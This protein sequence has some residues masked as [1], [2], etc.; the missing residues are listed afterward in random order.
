MEKPSVITKKC[1]E[2]RSTRSLRKARSTDNIP[3]KNRRLLSYTKLTE[4]HI[5]QVFSTCFSHNF[6]DCIH[7]DAQL[8]CYQFKRFIRTQSIQC[9]INS[10][11]SSGQ[12]LLVAGI[13]HHFEHLGFYLSSP[14]KFL[15]FVLK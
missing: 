10:H 3:P 12:R 5:Q 13:N 1:R 4:D 11:P 8:H 15:D 6:P 14:G 2:I 9:T 7:G